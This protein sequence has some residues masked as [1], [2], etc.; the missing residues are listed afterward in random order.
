[1]QYLL[2]LCGDAS[3]VMDAMRGLSS[4]TSISA[5]PVYT[6]D[7]LAKHR[8]RRWPS[9]NILVETLS[10]RPDQVYSMLFFGWLRVQVLYSNVSFSWKQK[11]F[12]IL[13]DFRF[14]KRLG[15]VSGFPRA[16]ETNPS[17]FSGTH[18]LSLSWRWII[19]C[20]TT[21]SAKKLNYLSKLNFRI[22]YTY[23]YIPSHK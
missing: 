9:W 19:N 1:M 8:I 2:W 3:P 10:S 20:R 15:R 14:I 7:M 12:S 17:I 13:Q 23:R 18:W 16:P 4:L 11:K 22:L 5:V 21:S 6:P